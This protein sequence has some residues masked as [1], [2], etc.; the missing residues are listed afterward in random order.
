MKPPILSDEQLRKGYEWCYKLDTD[1][2][3]DFMLLSSR[4]VAKLQ[5]DADV[6]YYEPLIQQTKAE[7]RARLKEEIKKE[8]LTD[9]E[10]GDLADLEVEYT[11][12]CSDG[13][14]TSTFDCRPVAQAQLQKILK[15]M[16]EK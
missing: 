6:A 4:S 12:P 10:I 15:K 14:Y 5:L 8:L 2:A 13:S 11:F 9:E 3:G 1:E 7:E 16:E